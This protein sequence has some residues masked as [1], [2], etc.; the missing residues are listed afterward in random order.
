M[1]GDKPRSFDVDFIGRRSLCPIGYGHMGMS[2][3][4]VVVDRFLSVRER[5]L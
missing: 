2:Q 4:E 3:Q 5:G 1:Q